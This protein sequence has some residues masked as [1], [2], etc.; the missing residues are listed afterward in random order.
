MIDF[1][2]GVKAWYVINI[3]AR[4]YQTPNHYVDTFKKLWT[5]DPLVS[6]NKSGR[7]M[8]LKYMDISQSNDEVFWISIGL[9]AYTII[10]KDG[11]YNIKK[12]EKVPMDNW[13]EDVVANKSETDLLF[14]PFVH[15]LVVKK[16]SK[17]S[18]NRILQYFHEALDT[19]EPESFDVNV[20]TDRDAIERII[21]ADSIYSIE[22]NVSYSN[23]GNTDGFRKLF[24]DKAKGAQ[25]NKMSIR[26][27][28]TIENPLVSEDD[29]LIPCL[30]NMAEQDGAI[31]AVIQEGTK[32]VTVDSK[33]HPK[34]I[35]TR[36]SGRDW[37][38]SLMKLIK[39]LY[40][41]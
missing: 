23:P 28:G 33:E 8:S 14:F 31:C 19:I 10:D 22:A 4:R 21:K 18:L 25:P 39:T 2:A 15:K 32:R 38:D 5:N 24:E 13:N 26:L 30:A 34:I 3:K 6:V 37:L 27:E 20:V 17:I 29:G 36:S 12:H 35:L 11:F 7:S 1:G 16:S 9:L 40:G 41:E